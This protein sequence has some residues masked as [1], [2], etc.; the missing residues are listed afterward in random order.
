MKEYDK[1]KSHKSS[2][3]PV[4][5][6]SF[7]NVR[8]PV[9]K[10]FTTLH[11]ATLHYTFWHVSSFHLNF[12]SLHF[13]SHH[14]TSFHCTFRWFSPHFYSF[15]FTPF[16]IAFLTLFLKILGLQ[17]KVPNISAGGWFQFLM[18]LFTKE[19]FPISVLC[20]LFLIFRTWSSLLK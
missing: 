8:H 15:H 5:C 7:N 4:I 14:Y 19:Y 11:P 16:I 6:I 10:T 13:T 3:P 18:V 1:W 20:F 2:K 12:L 9:T 17:E